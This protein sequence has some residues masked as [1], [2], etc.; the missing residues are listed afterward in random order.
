MW[1][2]AGLGNPGPKYAET[3][4]NVGFM[5]L[6]H[7]AQIR[8]IQSEKDEF[9]AK[10]A[11]LK[12]RGDDAIIAKPLTYM[13]LSGGPIQQIMSFYKIPMTNLLIVH[14]EVDLPFGTLKFQQNRGPGGHN[15]LKDIN[16]K[17]GSQNYG[18]L[19]FGVGRPPHP[20][21]EVADYVLQKF[22]DQEIS[23]LPPLID[24]AIEGLECYINEGYSKAA[25]KFNI[26]PQKEL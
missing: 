19:K 22:D 17:L 9:K 16:E 26:K 25:T 21:M 1:L 20:K 12:L 15:G 2:I 4:H 23:E 14:D 7:W 24:K 13:N 5:V 8:R 10:T 11:R 18:R 6:D 3:R